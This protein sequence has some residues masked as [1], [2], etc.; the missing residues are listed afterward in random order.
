VIK[1]NNMK[2]TKKF[3]PGNHCYTCE[4][5]LTR[6][7]RKNLRKSIVEDEK[8]YKELGKKLAEDKSFPNPFKKK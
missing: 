6:D 5:E 3:T 1:N 2:E 7:Q 8:K 4:I